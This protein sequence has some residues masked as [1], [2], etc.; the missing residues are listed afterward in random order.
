M[1][2]KLRCLAPDEMSVWHS[3]RGFALKKLQEIGIKPGDIICRLGNYYVYGFIHFS[4]VIANAT[5]SDFS[6]AGMVVSI[7]GNDI[8]LADVDVH[9]IRRQYF[10]EWLEAVRGD[11]IGVLRYNGDQSV[12]NRAVENCRLLTKEDPWCECEFDEDKRF[13]C[14]ELIC[15]CFLRAGVVLVKD[16]PINELPGWNWKLMPFAKMEGIDT[17]KPVF[18]V[19]NDKV[20]LYSSE[21]LSEILRLKLPEGNVIKKRKLTVHGA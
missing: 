12:I 3:H 7:E 21:H 8:L 4:K 10:P 5:G 20:G 1:F 2:E 6:H 9:G 15:W 11:S 17:S 14:V 16:T 13:C 18:C 19:G